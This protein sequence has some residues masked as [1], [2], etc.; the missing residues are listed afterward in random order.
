LED[1]DDR[2]LKSGFW[3]IDLIIMNGLLFWN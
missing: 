1:I 3:F 2:R